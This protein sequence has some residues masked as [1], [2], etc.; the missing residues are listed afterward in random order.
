MVQSCLEAPKLEAW[1]LMDMKAIIKI[2]S[3]YCE[4]DLQISELQR[5][6]SNNLINACCIAFNLDIKDIMQILV[7]KS[8]LLSAAH[9]A[10]HLA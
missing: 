5:I 7:C 2:D 6:L 9:S 3:Q 8:S 4:N 10:L 1:L